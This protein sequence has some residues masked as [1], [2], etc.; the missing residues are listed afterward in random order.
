M[1]QIVVTSD[2][3]SS[4]LLDSFDLINLVL[5]VGVP[6]AASVFKDGADKGF[7]A[8]FFNR[9]GAAMEVPLQKGKGRVCF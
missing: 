3:P 4:S 1:N 8:G 6:D 7:I 9:P 2:K 5:L